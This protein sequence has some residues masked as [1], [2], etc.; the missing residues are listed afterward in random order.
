[1]RKAPLYPVFL[2]PA[3]IVTLVGSAEILGLQQNVW[4][5]LMFGYLAG[6]VGGLWFG[7]YFRQRSGR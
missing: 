7:V 4:I 6:I 5:G 1:M 3:C 2:A